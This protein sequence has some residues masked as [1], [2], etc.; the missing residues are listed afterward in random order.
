[1][2]LQVTTKVRFCAR[3]KEF[4]RLRY[5]EYL[6]LEQITVRMNICY[7][8]VKRYSETVILKLGLWEEG[9]YGG[10][11]VTTIKA[12]KLLLKG[13]FINKEI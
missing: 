3:E 2:D 12:V 8:T 10:Q 1:M 9:M 13:G 4:I 11:H 6:T 5:D 7:R